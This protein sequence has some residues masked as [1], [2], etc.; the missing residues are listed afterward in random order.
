M[1]TLRPKFI[2]ELSALYTAEECAVLWRRSL[3]HVCSTEY[4]NTYFIRESELS[5][6]QLEALLDILKRLSEGEPLEYITGYAEFCSRRFIVNSSVLIP[7]LET[8]EMVDFIGRNY[9]SDQALEIVDL[10]TG[11]GCIAITLALMF[12]HSSVTAVDIS[13]SALRVAMDNAKLLSAT[14]VEFIEADMLKDNCL[15]GRKFDIIVSNPPYV[16]RSEI[17]TM[18]QRVLDYE[19]HTA[20]FVEDSDPLIFYK[21]IAAL[22]VHALKPKGMVMVETNQWLCSETASVLK[23]RNFEAETLK[24]LFSEERFVV[25]RA[26][27]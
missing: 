3:A 20:L 16:R 9:N 11:S 19:P 13:W 2:S 26:Q 22:A 23:E 10:G 12:P 21:S 17:S 6:E 1:R 18:P 4:S 25:A 27:F 5:Q 24:D 15:D 7:R 14:N 8:Q